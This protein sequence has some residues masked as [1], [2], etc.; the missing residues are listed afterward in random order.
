MN[1]GTADAL[2]IYYYSNNI[3]LQYVDAEKRTP[4]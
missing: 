2:N 1:I 4:V 3:Q